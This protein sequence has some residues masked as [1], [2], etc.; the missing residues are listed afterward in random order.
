MSIPA[1]NPR[2]AIQ[3]ASVLAALATGFL[4]GTTLSKQRPAQPPVSETQSTSPAAETASNRPSTPPVT[5]VAPSANPED[6]LTPKTFKELDAALQKSGKSPAEKRL[7]LMEMI[8]RMKPDELSELLAAEASNPDFFRRMRFDFQFTAKRLAELAPEKAAALWSATPSLRFQADAL[9][10]NWARK[11][12]QGFASWTLSLP[13]DVQRAAA[14]TLGEIAASNPEQFAAIAPQIA[15][16]P[17]AATAARRA[18]EALTQSENGARNE[19]A[20][21]SAP[22]TGRNPETAV[23]YAKSLPEGTMRNT[24]LAQLAR[25]PG[26]DLAKQPDIV[27][28]IQSLPREEAARLGRDLE[29]QSRG[30]AS[31]KSSVIGSLPQGPALDAALASNFRRTADKDAAQAAANLEQM[32]DLSTYP[33]AVRGF[34]DAT[35]SKDPAAAADWALSI[36]PSTGGDSAQTQRMAALERVA[37]EFAERN[38]EEAKKWLN[39]APLSD[40]EYLILSGKPR[41]K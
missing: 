13:K 4:A 3:I 20:D 14:S 11:D 40:R 23:A 7:A 19:A 8:G 28:A 34:V 24:A 36:N 31:A 32:K 2:P 1:G 9:L 25:M 37:R 41:P 39:T 12:P 29:E 6:L 22:R 27:S 15:E 18:M 21:T 33:A 17:G 5:P 38:P 16:T 30:D 10:G 26:I 35:A